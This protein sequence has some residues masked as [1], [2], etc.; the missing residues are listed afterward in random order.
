MKRDIMN[1]NKNSHQANRQE[2]PLALS[3]DAQPHLSTPHLPIAGT[4]LI[5]ATR[6]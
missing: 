4:F 1:V 5:S 6:F 2:C 3:A